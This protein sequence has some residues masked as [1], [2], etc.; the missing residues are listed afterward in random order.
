MPPDSETRVSGRGRAVALGIVAVALLLRT[1][2]SESWWLNPDE[3]IYFDILSARTSAGFWENIGWNAHPPLYYMILRGFGL[4]TWDFSWYRTFSVLGGCVAVWGFWLS[5]FE[6]GGR[7][8]RVRAY[9][10]GF[11]PSGSPR[12]TTPHW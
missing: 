1:V 12:R 4:V 11:L 6:L 2:G 5:G 10:P 9:P 7:G 8:R 3:G